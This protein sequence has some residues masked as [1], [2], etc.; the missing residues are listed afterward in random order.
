MTVTKQTITVPP[1]DIEW[2]LID[3]NDGLVGLIPRGGS[4]PPSEGDIIP[5]VGGQSWE[6][7]GFHLDVDQKNLF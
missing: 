2:A 6:T 5:D 4:F 1:E 7:T 3:E